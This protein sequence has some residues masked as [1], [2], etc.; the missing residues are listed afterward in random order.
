MDIFGSHWEAHF[1]QIEN[2]WKKK[3][4]EQDIILIP[5]DISWAIT[6]EEALPDLMR[7]ASLP[8]IK[9]LI[10][11]NHD[12]WWNSISRLRAALPSGMYALQNDALLI[13][14][15]VFCGT[16]GWS[17]PDKQ[18]LQDEKIYRRELQ[19]LEL[20][21]CHAEKIGTG[22]RKVALLHY[23]PIDAAG[24]DS[25]VSGMLERFRVHD[26]VYGHIHGTGVKTA[27]RGEKNGVRYHFV[28][29]DGLD[30]ALYQLPD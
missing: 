28:S 13:D 6:L 21:L 20:S 25:P 16:R 17:V 4:S 15:I 8:G 11:G 26:V 18:D 5:G 9:I 24:L 23:P 22:K 12:Y 27:F 10:K 29:C 3:A 2:D 7:I 30:F 19:R 1:D 14:D